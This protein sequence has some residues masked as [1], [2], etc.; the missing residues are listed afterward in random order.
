MTKKNVVHFFFSAQK[1][2]TVYFDQ[3][4]VYF[5]F[6]SC[7]EIIASLFDFLV[8]LISRMYCIYPKYSDR[9]A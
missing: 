8:V 4:N 9:Q 5:S 3:R 2:L 6:E 7:G 1:Y